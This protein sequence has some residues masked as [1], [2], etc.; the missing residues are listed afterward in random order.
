MGTGSGAGCPPQN[1]VM[2]YPTP[3]TDAS[4]ADAGNQCTTTVSG[5]TTTSNCRIPSGSGSGATSF[6]LNATGTVTAGVVT[7]TISFEDVY[8]N[9]DAAPATPLCSYSY[10]WSSGTGAGS[11]SGSGS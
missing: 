11:S 2:V 4:V 3:P 9:Q 5:C 8:T 7:G 1:T 6:I 10:S